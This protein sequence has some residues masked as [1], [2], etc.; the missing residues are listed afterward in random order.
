MSQ[1]KDQS[2]IDN[3]FKCSA[4]FGNGRAAPTHPTPA[5]A[6]VPARLAST[7]ANSCAT[8]TSC[9]A[10]PAQLLALISAALIAISFNRKNAGSSPES[11]PHATH[12]ELVGR[13]RRARRFQFPL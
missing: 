13:D 4:T 7:T 6:L 11:D 12:T 8:N 2:N 1:R 10:V 3:W 5:T 9:A